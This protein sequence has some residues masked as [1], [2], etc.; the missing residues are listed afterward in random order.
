MNTHKVSRNDIISNSASIFY[1]GLFKWADSL[2]PAAK[3]GSYCDEDIGMILWN[4]DGKDILQ[5]GPAKARSLGLIVEEF[6]AGWSAVLPMGEVRSLISARISKGA[7]YAVT[8]R[9][10]PDDSR[11]QLTTIEFVRTDMHS[12]L[13]KH[14]W[15]IA[16]ATNEAII[17]YSFIAPI[18]VRAEE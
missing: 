8:A 9:V 18:T 12:A 3:I 2:S 13:Q 10:C 1:D 14:G 17:V 11:V 6:A 5:F 7:C 16:P 15:S 4:S